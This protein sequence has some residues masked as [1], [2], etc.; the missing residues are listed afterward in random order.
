[1]KSLLFI[2]LTSLSFNSMAST[3]TCWNIFS[4]N[5]NAPILRADITNK[6]ILSK[7]IFNLNE[8]SFESFFFNKKEEAGA[9]WPGEFTLSQSE[10]TN[11]KGELSAKILTAARS[12]YKG[13]NQYTFNFGTYSIKS[14]YLVTQGEY[15][16]RLILPL[17][18]SKSN[19]ETFR[20]RDANEKSNSVL[21]LP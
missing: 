20:I 13:N 21:I 14:P 2:I 4:S 17:N 6:V 7:A 10:L 19:L 5:S 1:M 9:T 15:E 11:P 3:L 8:S 12:P 16:A 18:L